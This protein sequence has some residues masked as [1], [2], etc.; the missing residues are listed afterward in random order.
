VAKDFGAS[1]HAVSYAVGLTL[2][3]RPLGA[4]IFG[5]LA[6]RFGRR[7]T[8]M[9]DVLL[10]SFVELLSGFAP[11]L[12]ALIILRAIFGVAMG[13]EWGVGTSLTMETIP[14]K[15]RGIVSGLLHSGYPLGYL[16]AS[17]L[18]GVAYPFIGWRGMFILGALPALL[19]VYIRTSIE[20]S[21]VWKAGKTPPA[22]LPR[23][24]K[25]IPF[26]L[27]VL[28]L[29]LLIWL[30]P[31]IA[32]TLFGGR[33]FAW[34]H[35]IGISG[36]D[37]AFWLYALLLIIVALGIGGMTKKELPVFFYL[38]LLMTAFNSFTHA[39]GDPYPSF[40][41]EQLHYSTQ[42]TSLIVITYN[43]A[44]I[45]G[46]L[47]FGTLS[48]K[49]GRKKCIIWAALLSVPALL[50]ATLEVPGPLGIIILIIGSSILQFL[51]N[52]AWG[53]I[54]AHLNELSPKNIRGTFPGFT[55]Q[56]GNLF[57]S[58]N[59]TLQMATAEH[60]NH[61]IGQAIAIFMVVI[62]L[63]ITTVTALGPEA[64]GVKL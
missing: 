25:G 9:A 45:L 22:I 53:A 59:L 2:M 8:M 46:A 6:D 52:G 55:Y 17:I 39:S 5:I 20:E 60:F 1:L 3:M 40:L 28:I 10:Y 24:L 38:I 15:A 16:L 33:P 23:L 57:A 56:L 29:I 51:V 7:P 47:T 62:A 36:P 42:T 49:Y 41:R 32:P 14:E 27:P 44:A 61:N 11:N 50:P 30:L 58:Y 19:A 12:T 31:I 26:Y 54:P 35:W 48:E 63:V 34:Q 64:K 13:G 21:P 4:L 37:L 43:V 18:Y